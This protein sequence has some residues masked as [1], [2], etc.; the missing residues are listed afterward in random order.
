MVLDFL[1]CQQCSNFDCMQGD[2]TGHRIWGWND[3]E[4]YDAVSWNMEEHQ[5]VDERICLCLFLLS[6]SINNRKK[7][8]KN[9]IS[10]SALFDSSI[11]FRIIQRGIKMKKC[12]MGR[13]RWK[14]V[15]TIETA[16]L[17]GILLPVLAGILWM[18]VLLYE[19]GALQGAVSQSVL[20]E[21]MK[22]E[23]KTETGGSRP[24]KNSLGNAKLYLKLTRIDRK[25][26]AEGEGNASVP[27]IASVFFRNGTLVWKVHEEN[28]WADTAKQLREIFQKRTVSESG[29]SR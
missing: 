3:V 26:I 21:N 12:K 8:Q 5:S 23:K 15:Y 11:S 2:T 19:K 6:R 24:E 17:M 10:I 13:K 29:E 14:A 7:E 18:C 28:S 20:L 9:R 16:I 1:E 22:E 27:G 25:L 4:H